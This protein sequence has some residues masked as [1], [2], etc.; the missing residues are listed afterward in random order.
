MVSSEFSKTEKIREI[1]STV[2]TVTNDLKA[3]LNVFFR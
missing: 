3:F 1:A 2:F